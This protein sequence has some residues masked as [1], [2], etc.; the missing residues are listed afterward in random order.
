MEGKTRDEGTSWGLKNH[1]WPIWGML[2]VCPN[3]NP[4]SASVLA[5]HWR[6]NH[7]SLFHVRRHLQNT[8]ASR[9]RWQL[10]KGSWC[11]RAGDGNIEPTEI[12]YKAPHS[13][14]LAAWF[15][16]SSVILAGNG[17]AATDVLEENLCIN[18]FVQL[19]A[20]LSE[21]GPFLWTLCGKDGY[22]W[23]IPCPPAPEVSRT[24][25][26]PCPQPVPPTWRRTT[27]FKTS[28]LSWGLC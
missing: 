3:S 10:E 21:R 7:S 5:H 9:M 23:K 20:E 17:N 8:G 4:S 24:H 27:H 25:A 12:S 2:Y 14:H 11:H 13:F 28:L 18:N 16:V 22:F 6:T 26:A 19:Y 15:N 1:I